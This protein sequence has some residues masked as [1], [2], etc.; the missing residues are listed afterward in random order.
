VSIRLGDG[1]GSGAIAAR[2]TSEHGFHPPLDILDGAARIVDPIIDGVNTGAHV[3]GKFLKIT[4]RRLVEARF[5]ASGA[6]PHAHA[7]H[8]HSQARQ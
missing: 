1:R 5:S 4:G 6:S 8:W 2:K 3:W 7:E